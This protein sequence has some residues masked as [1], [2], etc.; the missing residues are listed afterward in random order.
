MQTGYDTISF[1]LIAY[2]T[3]SEA[4]GARENRGL[5]FLMVKDG[6]I[7]YASVSIYLDLVVNFYTDPFQVSRFC[8]TSPG[9]LWSYLLL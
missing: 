1:L 8:A 7:Y 5:K 2:N 9:R 6:I 4:M 3:F